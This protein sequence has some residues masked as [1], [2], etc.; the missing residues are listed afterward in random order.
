M[1][2]RYVLGNLPGV[3]ALGTCQ[4][5]T[6]PQTIRDPFEGRFGFGVEEENR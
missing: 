1:H 5:E 2:K 3:Y 6:G 4:K